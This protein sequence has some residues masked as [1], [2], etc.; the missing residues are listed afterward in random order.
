MDA[1]RFD[2]VT[3]TLA[4]GRSRRDILAALAV[5]AETGVSPVREAEARKKK[6]PVTICRNGQTLSVTKK[7]KQKHLQPG[8]TEGPCPPLAPPVSPPPGPPPG[9]PP[10][11]P[12]PTCPDVLPSADLQA[13]INAAES[14]STLQLC[15]GTFRITRT[16]EVEKNLTIA[17]AGVDETILDGEDQVPVLLIGGNRIVT[18]QD[19]TI[20]RGFASGEG[21]GGG[22]VNS[23]DVTL[24]KTAV[25]FCE[26]FKGGGINNF[27]GS[28][29]TLN[30]GSVVKN[31]TAREDGGGILNDGTVTMNEGSFVR[32]NTATA[33]GG[34]IMTQV[35][36]LIMNAGSFVVENTAAE[37][38]G[39]GGGRATL[40]PQ[41]TVEGNEPD[42]CN[43]AIGACQ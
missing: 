25:T 35:G 39:I 36:S 43:P 12:P 23:G 15:P 42:N 11:P 32:E 31:N 5:L 34:G 10:P 2:I 7:K 4:H 41:S 22:I 1:N 38:G 21:R 27:P 8:D 29:L 33:K 26:A 28:K 14:G 40:N 9:P 13:A 19:L 3:R 17:G 24:R 20:T 30:V 6:K 16:L 37:G 18:V